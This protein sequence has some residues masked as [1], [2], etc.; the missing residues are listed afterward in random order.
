MNTFPSLRGMNKRNEGLLDTKLG[1]RTLYNFFFFKLKI[2]KL[3]NL[4]I[5]TLEK[6]LHINK[7]ACY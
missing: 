3:R 6:I 7:V 4:S 2:L 5:K 1:I